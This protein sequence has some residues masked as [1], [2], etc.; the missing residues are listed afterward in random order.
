MADVDGGADCA[1]PVV[2]VAAEWVGSRVGK[3]VETER[4]AAGGTVAAGAQAEARKQKTIGMKTKLG[5]TDFSLL[6]SGLDH[7]LDVE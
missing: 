1:L 7:L 2:V 4:E 5:R 6:V 3:A